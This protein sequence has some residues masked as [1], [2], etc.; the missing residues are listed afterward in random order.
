MDSEE[1]DLNK[2]IEE[3]VLL[4]IYLTSWEEKVLDTKVL[5]SWKGYPFEVLDELKSKY[6]LS[7]SKVAKSV[8]LTDTGIKKAKELIEKYLKKGLDD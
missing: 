5:R 8:Y 4:L 3:M 7:G 2:N 1:Q 6:L